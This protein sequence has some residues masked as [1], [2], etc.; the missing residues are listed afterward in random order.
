MFVSYSTFESR[1]YFCDEYLRYEDFIDECFHLVNLTPNRWNIEAI[2]KF[3]FVRNH[4]CGQ[5]VV[6]MRK[7]KDLFQFNQNGT[8]DE[9]PAN[10]ITKAVSIKN[11]KL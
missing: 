5:R 10:H 3:E 8:Y 9:L 7:G 1:L 6:L 4:I 2:G 11:I